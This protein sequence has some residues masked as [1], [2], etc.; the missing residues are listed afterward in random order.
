MSEGSDFFMWDE[1]G[2]IAS[3]FADLHQMQ[4]QSPSSFSEFI[5]VVELPG[6]IEALQHDV[7][8]VDFI[9]EPDFANTGFGHP[10]AVISVEFTSEPRVVFIVEAK[11]GAY[12]KACSPKANRGTSGYNSSLN[13]QLELNYCLTLALSQFG[14]DDNEL[15]EPEWILSSPYGVER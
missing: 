1:R 12:T 5:S 13:G 14:S 2:L 3:F 10:D 9:I 15:I 8:K 4:L 11:R 7:K 6:E